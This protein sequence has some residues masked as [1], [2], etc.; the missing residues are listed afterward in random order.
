VCPICTAHAPVL[1]PLVGARVIVEGRVKTVGMA[2]GGLACAFSPGEAQQVPSTRFPPPV[3]I[4]CA[5]LRNQ[6]ILYCK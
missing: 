3:C 5:L 4:A 1:L 6:P 2:G